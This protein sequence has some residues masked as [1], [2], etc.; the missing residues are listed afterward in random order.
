MGLADQVAANIK[1]VR[2]AKGLSQDKL[3]KRCNPPTV[4][5]QIDKLESGERR[6]TLDWVERIA[7]GLGVDPVQLVSGEASPDGGVQFT[8]SEQVANEVARVQANIL[9]DCT[10]DD[11]V[12]IAQLA[13]FQRELLAL[14]VR[15]PAAATNITVAR[16]ALELL[17]RRPLG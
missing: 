1:G 2:L 3:A 6:M 12:G 7:V 10:G 11:S 16:P 9:S 14:V 13:A 15:H 17:A 4:Y 8:L 5:Q